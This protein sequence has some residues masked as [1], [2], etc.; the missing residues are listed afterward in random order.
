MKIVLTLVLSALVVNTCFSQ[1]APQPIKELNSDLADEIEEAKLLEKG[2][3]Q[4]EFGYAYTHFA[5]GPQP[6]IGQALLRYGLLKKFELRFLIEDGAARDRYL[7]ET[8]ESTS[9][10]AFSFKFALLEDHKVLPDIT[11]I[12]YLKLPF[13]SHTSEQQP[14]WAPIVCVTLQN[15]FSDKWKLQYNPGIMQEAFSKEWLSFFNA[16][17]HYMAGEKTEVFL[18]Y[19]GQ[20]QAG[21]DPQHNAGL[22]ASYQLNNFL[23][24]FGVAGTTLNYNSYNL[25]LSGGLAMRL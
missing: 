25:Y 8:V 2:E 24:F 20:Y 4:A 13:T 16:S 3:F 10:L 9:P 17:L 23:E 22:G 18:E 5:E 6:K 15:K 12:S 14:Y 7:E 19:Y 1:N 11:L 21:K